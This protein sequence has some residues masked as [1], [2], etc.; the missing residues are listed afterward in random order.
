MLLK[1]K[2]GRNPELSAKLLRL[3]FQCSWV[4]VLLF[5]AFWLIFSLWGSSQVEATG[6]ALIYTLFFWPVAVIPAMY[7]K[8]RK[9]KT[10]ED[11]NSYW[12]TTPSSIGQ[13]NEWAEDLEEMRPCE[14]KVDDILNY[15]RNN[16]NALDLP[17]QN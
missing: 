5:I 12:P 15:Y 16:P 3:F 1:S 11:A 13:A 2:F 6:W 8:S 9:E 7:I 10:L 4:I 17:K 14:S